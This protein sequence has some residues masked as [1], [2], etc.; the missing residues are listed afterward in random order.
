MRYL[1]FMLNS[2]ATRTFKC[3]KPFFSWTFEWTIKIPIKNLHALYEATKNTVQVAIFWNVLFVATN[4]HPKVVLQV[5]WRKICQ[6][7]VVNSKTPT[8]VGLLPELCSPARSWWLGRGMRKKRA[9]KASATAL[10][11]VHRAALRVWL[12]KFREHGFTS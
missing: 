11:K 5:N 1:S 12:H 2:A 10:K 8:A 9:E 3:H 6:W 7:T 4:P